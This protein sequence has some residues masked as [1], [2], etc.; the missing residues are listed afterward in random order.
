[1]K[2]L[3]IVASIAVLALAG[4]LFVPSLAAP[5]GTPQ[6][7]LTSSQFAFVGSADGK[8]DGHKEG[9]VDGNHDGID[10]GRKDGVDDGFTDG[11]TEGIDDGPVDGLTDGN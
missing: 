3:S 8:I 5:P 10:E 7:I 11:L 6:T 9:S 2:W 1:M 4:A